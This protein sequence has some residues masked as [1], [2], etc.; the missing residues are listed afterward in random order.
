MGLFDRNKKTV[1]EVFDDVS[2]SLLV[3]DESYQRRHVW[4]VQDRVRLIETILLGYIIP[5]VF[6]WN[7]SVNPDT[8]ETITHIVDGQQRINAIVD[9]IDDHF[10]LNEKYLLDEN[11]KS[12]YGGLSFS[13]LPPE[14]KT[15]IWSYKLSIVDVDKSLSYENIKTLFYRLNLTNY[16]LN[17]QEKRNSQD[18]AFGDKAE[19]LSKEKFWDDV[20]LFSAND[21]RRM[22]DT[23]Y[24]CGIYILAKDGM[25]DQTNN[26]KIN[27]FYDDYSESFDEDNYLQDKIG[28]AMD[29]IKSWYNENTYSFVSKKVQM[30]TLF[31]LAFR[32]IDDGIENTD[33]LKIKIEK[34]IC[35]YNLFRNEYEMTFSEDESLSKIQDCI[36]KYKLASSEGVNKL[37]NRMIRYE[38][39]YKICLS[40]DEIIDSLDK[41]RNAYFE[42]SKNEKNDE[43]WQINLFDVDVF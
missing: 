12:N 25:V 35:A 33:K 31:C 21:V 28:F 27:E 18:S 1:K 37:Q 3:V 43:N 9:Y 36:K 11:I 26:T 17:A 10:I 40:N 7:S 20:R 22:K 34:F 38:Q 6:F 14:A 15:K 5:E 16:N 24:C 41:V 39:L 42:L 2:N 29:I 8:G 13:A 4:L 30:Y 32:M 23:E 19:S